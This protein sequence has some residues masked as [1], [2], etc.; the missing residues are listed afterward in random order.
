MISAMG[1]RLM[2]EIRFM[3]TPPERVSTG[4]RN[5]WAGLPTTDTIAPYLRLRAIVSGE[6][7]QVTG[8]VCNIK[9]IDE[10]LR[11][12]TVPYLRDAWMTHDKAFSIPGMM[13]PMWD[14][15][16]PI[17]PAETTLERITLC[18]SPYL[19]FSV[20]RGDI[21]MVTLSYEFEFSAS[22]RLSCDDLSN[23]ENERIFGRCANRN[24]H[25]HNYML[26]V[27]LAGQPDARTGVLVPLRQVEDVVNQRVID[28]F[29]HKHLNSDCAEFANLNPS[30]ENITRI[31]YEKLEG[32][33]APATLRRVR[34]Y[35]TAKTYAEYPA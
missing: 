29:D 24:G 26:L 32:A 31:I 6:P 18:S 15:L 4:R 27:T 8:Y 17:M 11:E 33:F 12:H 30:V 7:Q 25:G 28:V 21:T 20:D 35:E 9:V 19:S 34:V 23:E 2:R 13:R 10:F 14:R 22:H 16:A 5:S 3:L 1:T